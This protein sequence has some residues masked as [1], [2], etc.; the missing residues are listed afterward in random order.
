MAAAAAFRS[1]LPLEAGTAG[2]PCTGRLAVL[3]STQRLR[4]GVV[5]AFI[6][7]SVPARYGPC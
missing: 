4:A 3:D 2:L 1:G 7:I 5:V 6:V